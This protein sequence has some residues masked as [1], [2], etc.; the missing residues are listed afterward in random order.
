MLL[1][2][3]ILVGV[4][5]VVVIVVLATGNGGGLAAASTSTTTTTTST[6]T[7]TLPATTTSSE[8]TTSST[9][10]TTSTTSTTTTSTTTTSTTTTS[11][12]TTSTTTTTTAPPG[13]GLDP[14]AP[15]NFGE[16]TLDAGFLPDPAEVEVV[17]GGSVD[18]SVALPGGCGG[19]ATSSPDVDLVW[20]GSTGLLRIFFLPDDLNAEEADTVLVVAEPSGAVFCIDD[21]FE[22]VHPTLDFEPSEAGYYS[23]WVASFFEGVNV[24]G[25]LYVTEDP[26][27]HP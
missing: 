14:S 4:A 18:L 22:T 9:N 1:S 7:T 20:G 21:S 23:I 3:L 10:T 27:L 15:P 19:Y 25:T 2:S 26:T 5:A 6:S 24:P 17:S 12:T 8:A 11:T 16:I 13:D